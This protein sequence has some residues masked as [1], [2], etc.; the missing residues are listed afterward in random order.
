[1]W[2]I[3]NRYRF[4]SYLF[5]RIPKCRFYG[6]LMIDLFIFAKSSLLQTFS[7]C[8]EW[9]LRLA[10]VHGLPMAEASLDAVAVPRGL[11]RAGSVVVVH[12]LS[13][14]MQNLPGPGIKPMS[15]ALAGRFS[16][17]GPPGKS[18]FQSLCELNHMKLS[19]FVG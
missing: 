13:C 18:Q 12:A 4:Y 3:I 10:P 16:I 15:P 1:M 14:S 2:D 11:Q 7:N 19:F 8:R 17:T 6:F 9:G 5:M